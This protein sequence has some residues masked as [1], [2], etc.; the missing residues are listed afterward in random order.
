MPL[1][2]PIVV[3]FVLGWITKVPVPVRLPPKLMA[4]VVRIRLFDPAAKVE[5]VVIPE[6]D[7]VVAAPKVTAPL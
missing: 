5:L 4:S 3:V 2:I 6:A 7:K 1:P